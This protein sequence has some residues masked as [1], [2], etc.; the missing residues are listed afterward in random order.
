MY[1]QLKELE[2]KYCFVKVLMDRCIRNIDLP[3]KHFRYILCVRVKF[4]SVVFFYF[5]RFI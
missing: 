2:D 1:N 4:D 3:L 5:E